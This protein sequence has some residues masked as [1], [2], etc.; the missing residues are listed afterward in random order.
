MTTTAQQAGAATGTTLTPAEFQWITS[1]LRER[2]GI[3]LH[4][5]KQAMVMGRLER[6][7]RHLGMRSYT[8]Y[9]K[10]IRRPEQAREMQFAIDLL[11][12]NET[13]LFREKAHFDLLPDLLPRRGGLPVRVW[14]AASS[15]GEEAATIALVL[16][17]ALGRSGWEIVGTDVSTRVVE[18]ARRGLYPIG[19]AERVPPELLRR[20]CLRGKGE[21]EGYFSLNPHLRERIRFVAA[22]LLEPL[23]EIGMFDVVF[24]RNVLIYFDNPTRERVLRAATTR[25][26]P[27]GYLLTS[28]SESLSGIDLPLRSIAPSV[29]RYRETQ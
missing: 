18:T 25:L 19:A 11:T 10:L 17:D 8:E 29:Y 13:Y 7:L 16:A 23:P 21:Y 2:T 5:G 4:D 20:H 27:G 15:T 6:R 24:I 12:T 9:F 22:N 3:D 1:F 26:H 28:H 14:S